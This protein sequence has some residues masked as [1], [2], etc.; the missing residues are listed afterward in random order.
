MQ[1]AATKLVK[2]ATELLNK[3]AASTLEAETKD[4][5]EMPQCHKHHISLQCPACLGEASGRV[6]TRAKRR[7]AMH[8]LPLAWKARRKYPK[9]KRYRSHHF[10]PVTG[11]CPCGYKQPA[12]YRKSK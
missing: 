1:T 9:C 11:V 7:A 3:A 5:S 12:K 8:N 6:N 2:K 4:R 10:S